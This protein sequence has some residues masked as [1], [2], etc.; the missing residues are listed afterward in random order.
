MSSGDTTIDLDM[1][2]T[3]GWEQEQVYLAPGGGAH[4]YNYHSQEHDQAVQVEVGAA[5]C[6]AHPRT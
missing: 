6:T 2:P 1:E 4:S 5:E 3:G